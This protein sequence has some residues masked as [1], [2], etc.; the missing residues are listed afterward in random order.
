MND[1]DFM[2]QMDF[3]NQM[4]I[5]RMNQA[6]ENEMARNIQMEGERLN[7]QTIEEL[8][9]NDQLQRDQQMRLLLDECERTSLS[10]Q[11]QLEFWLNVKDRAKLTINSIWEHVKRFWR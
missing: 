5:S 3:Q 4:E 11:Q 10:Y 9:R 7:Q 8:T 2:M 6:H 1:F